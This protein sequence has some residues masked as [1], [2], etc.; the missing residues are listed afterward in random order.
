VV[1]GLAAL[2]LLIELAQIPIPNRTFLWVDA[3]A[4]TIGAF[5]GAISAWLLGW[6]IRRFFRA[7]A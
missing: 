4:N 1:P 6:T 5:L 7:R 3:A 2:G